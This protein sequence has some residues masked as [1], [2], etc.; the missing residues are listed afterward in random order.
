MRELLGH[1]VTELTFVQRSVTPAFPTAE[2]FADF[3]L[4]N[5]GP[6][7]TAADR[8]APE[9]RTAFRDDLVSLARQANQATDG[10]FASKWDYLL[11]LATKA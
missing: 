6:T 2:F 7:K 9:G 10:S 11:A 3:Q 4:A 5:Y 1:D 8:L